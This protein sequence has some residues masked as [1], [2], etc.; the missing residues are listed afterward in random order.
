MFTSSLSFEYMKK[1]FTLLEINQAKIER[2]S[3]KSL[4]GFTLIEIMVSMTIFLI[5]MVS[6]IELFISGISA[7]KKSLAL[8]TLSDSASYAI[9]YMSRTIRMAKKDL[10]GTYISAGCNFENPEGDLAKIRFLNYKKED[11]WFIL[12][13]KQ[14]KEKK[15]DD[16]GFTALTSD[17]FQVNKLYFELSGQCQTDD[18]QSRVTIVMEI[19]TKEVEPQTLNIQTTISQRDL[20]V[21]Y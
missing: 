5:V 10:T 13:N 14:I 7:Q 20:D 19:Q 12:D 15:D 4:T 9:E 18:L 16:I 21:K 11:Q 17:N 3:K 1:S 8:Q 6:V 2:K